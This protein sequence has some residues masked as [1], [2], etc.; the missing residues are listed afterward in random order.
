MI[1]LRLVKSHG[2][3]K[4]LRLEGHAPA[5][6]GSSGENILCA[7]VSVLSQSCFLYLQKNDLLREIVWEKGRLGFQIT[8]PSSES[9]ICMEILVTGMQD[10][11]DQ[12]PKWIDIYIGEENGT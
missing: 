6:F 3:Y 7:G 4:S 5:S 1:S 11:K 8:K 2:K 9:E 10:L 12:Y